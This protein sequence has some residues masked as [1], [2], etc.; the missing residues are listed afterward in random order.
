MASKDST[1]WS[2]HP[3]LGALLRCAAVVVPLVIALAAALLLTRLLPSAT[4]WPGRVA[5]WAAVLGGSTAAM[6]LADRVA[7]R[8]LPLAVLLDLALVFPDRAPSRLRAARTTSVRELEQRLVALRADGVGGRPIDAAETLVTLVGILGLHDRRTRGHSERVRAFTDLLTAELGLDEDARVRVRW[9]A[10]VHDI[11]KLTVPGGVL[12]GGRDLSEDDWAALRRHPDEGQ[13]LAAGLVPWLGEWGRAI[14]EHHE[15]WDG[16]GY[17]LGLAGAQIGYGARIVTVADAFDTMT[18]AR[19]YS[20]ARSAAAAREELARCAGSHFDPQVVRAF[21]AVSLGRVGWVLGPVTWLAQ[22]PF[23]AAADRAGR[24]VKAAGAGAAIGGLVLVGALPGPGAAAAG[25]ADAPLAAGAKATTSVSAAPRTTPAA[26]GSAPVASGSAPAAPRNAP[27]ALPFTDASAAAGPPTAST[28][29]AAASTPAGPA[30]AAPA[31]AAAASPA[32]AGAP[33]VP[34]R[35]SA[36]PAPVPVPAPAPSTTAGNNGNGN[37]A[38]NPK[39]TQG[40]KAKKPKKPKKA[41]GNGQFGAN[42]SSHAR[43]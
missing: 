20:K 6:L 1:R 24:S 16:S 14:A 32:A 38:G 28:G 26:P 41:S 17:P 13:R 12:N 5:W 43:R 27:V 15:R 10:L 39:A 11:G 35:P 3:V 7:R 25:A 36:S 19:S 8:L 4:D 22:L 9:A 37:G 40:K 30:A 29:S 42:N 21:L 2:A 33:V 31:S 34:V 18:S 23:V